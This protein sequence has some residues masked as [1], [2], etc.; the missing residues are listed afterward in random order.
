MVINANILT[1][2]GILLTEPLETNI[3]EILIKIQ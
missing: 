2:A 1:K 3:R